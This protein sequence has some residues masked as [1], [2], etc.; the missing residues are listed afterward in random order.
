MQIITPVKHSEWAAPIVPVVKCYG[1]IHLCGNYKV[2]INPVL[3]P[4]T[5]PLPQVDDLFAALSGGKVF[6]KLDLSH[7]YLQVHLDDISKKL[8]TVNTPPGLFQYERL[9]FWHLV[10][11]IAVPNIPI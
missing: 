6:S 9:A 4:D 8:I 10:S 2:T 5:Y 1:T 11:F 7:A 3:I